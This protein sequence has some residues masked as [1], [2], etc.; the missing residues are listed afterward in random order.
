VELDQ[1]KSAGQSRLKIRTAPRPS[2]DAYIEIKLRSKATDDELDRFSELVTTGGEVAAGLRKRVKTAFALGFLRYEGKIVGTAA[3]K[4]PDPDYRKRVFEK[5][6]SKQLVASYPYELGW[7]FL[8]HAHRRK[9]RMM[10]LIVEMMNQAKKLG[11]FATTR[12]SNDQMLKILARLGFVRDGATYPST[13]NTGDE[14]ALLLRA[15]DSASQPSGSA[16]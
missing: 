4:N 6:Q 16:V 8:D 11:V 2:P 3:L 9:G 5:A 7:V 10:P 13:Q 12:T 1:R 14:L 15:P